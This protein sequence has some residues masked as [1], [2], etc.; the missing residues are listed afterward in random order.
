MDMSRPSPGSLPGTRSIPIPR[1]SAGKAGL[2]SNFELSA[3][4][5][6]MKNLVWCLPVGAFLL[7]GCHKNTNPAQA[8]AAPGTGAK[9]GEPGAELAQPLA[10]P[11]AHVVARAENAVREAVVG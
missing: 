8:P 5:C 7:F 3:D 10:P 6:A 1:F 2:A 9:A 11:P 4:N